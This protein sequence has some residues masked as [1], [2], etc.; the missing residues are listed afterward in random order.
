MSNF[1][2]FNGGFY[3]EQGT[4]H[5]VEASEGA[6]TSDAMSPLEFT[7]VVAEGMSAAEALAV[8]VVKRLAEFGFVSPLAALTLAK[9]FPER[10]RATDWV[11]VKQTNSEFTD[12]ES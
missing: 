5:S 1:C 4:F 7:K 10:V 12:E 6:S 2:A 8:A 3:N 9:S 11:S